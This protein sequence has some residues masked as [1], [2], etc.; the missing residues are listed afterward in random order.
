MKNLIV[1]LTSG[2]ILTYREVISYSVKNGILVIK[3]KD[4]LLNY[5]I[6]NIRKYYE[7]K[8]PMNE[9]TSSTAKW[10]HD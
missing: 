2:E 8:D 5:P 10:L 7:M 6:N 9:K 1:E 4:L 3:T